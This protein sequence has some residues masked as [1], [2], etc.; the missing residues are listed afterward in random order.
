MTLNA[1]II[2]IG[3]GQHVLLPVFRADPRTD[4]L[5]LC[6]STQER[7][8][9]VADEHNVPR[10]YGNWRDLIADDDIDVIAIATPPHLQPEIAIATAEAGKHLLLEKP[11]AT[12]LAGAQRMAAAIEAA[13]VA[14]VVDFEFPEID[15]WGRARDLL[16]QI[17]GLRHV[18]VLWN[19]ETYANRNNLTNWKTQANGGGTLYNFVS[20]VF[21]NL[22]WFVGENIARISATLTK[23]PSDARD[24][25]TVNMIT[26]EFESG[27]A[28]SITV[29]SHAFMGSG[30]CWMFYG[31]DGTLVLENTTRDYIYGFT[32]RY[33]LR[34]DDAFREV[35]LPA[36]NPDVD[37][38]RLATGR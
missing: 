36:E 16:P 8:Q 4:V 14:N 11:L 22:G 32:L 1:G 34:G 18:E 12:T 17:G 3:Y 38:R 27:L 9:N 6:A 26:A 29:S 24:G 20:H 15:A 23:A 31:D 35:E 10:A 30:H 33:A 19:V 7:A 25:D 28:A 5:A 13:G 2:G 21:Y 37:G